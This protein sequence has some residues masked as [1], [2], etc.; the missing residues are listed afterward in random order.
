MDE[1]ALEGL[2]IAARSYRT[3]AVDA[4]P[5]GANLLT[6]NAGAC[7]YRVYHLFV[8]DRVAAILTLPHNLDPPACG[9]YIQVRPR[10]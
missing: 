8:T 6:G 9:R 3:L 7:G 1:D 4:E 2:P 10:T 5:M